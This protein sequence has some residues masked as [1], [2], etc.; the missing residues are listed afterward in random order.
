MEVFG[1]Y[2]YYYNMF[3]GDKDYAKEARDVDELIRKYS[4]EKA[5]SILN[6]GCGTGRHDHE[7][8]KMGYSVRG[9]DLSSN[10]VRVAS[11]NYK[12]EIGDTLQFGVG[13][14][15]T[16]RDNLSYDIVTSL[17][18][19]MSYQN[20]NEDLIAAF[21]TAYSELKDDGFFIFDAWYGPG[22]LTDPPAV[23]VKKVEDD[24]NELIRY[25]L[26]I[27]HWNENVVDVCY[28][29]HIIDKKTAVTRVIKEIHSMRYLFMPEV[30]QMLQQCGLDLIDC[31]DCTTLDR[32]DSRSWT[33]YF[34]AQKKS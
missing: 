12:Q 24:N 3:Y 16:Y 27:M 17:F 25:A 10:M 9:I 7:L 11:D 13:D 21:T 5:K 30:E 33:A 15:R 31:L 34:V 26:P 18:H 28:E 6:I 8:S 2:A 19:V 32:P 23:R 4:K 22:V 29:V 14:A 1:D 20:R